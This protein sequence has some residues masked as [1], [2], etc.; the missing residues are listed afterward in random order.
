MLSDNE[1]RPLAGRFLRLRIT[2]VGEV[3]ALWPT[4]P[5][6]ARREGR[7]AWTYLDEIIV[8]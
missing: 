4:G 3:P 1:R 5:Q 8:R 7:T 2:G 6:G